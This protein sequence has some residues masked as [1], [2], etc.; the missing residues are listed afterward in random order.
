MKKKPLLNIKMC[1]NFLYRSPE[2]FPT[3]R[4]TQRH[5]HSHTHTHT[6]SHTH[7]HTH[8]H[9]HTHT[10]THTEYI[11][12][13]LLHCDVG[14]TNALYLFVM[15]TLPVLLECVAADEH[16]ALLCHYAATNGNILPTF[17]DKLPIPSSTVKN[18]V[19]D[20]WLR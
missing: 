7:T 3:L 4:R 20:L 12:V 19:A 8:T 5:T 18:V 14:F 2:A 9:S 17:R 11:I 15:R 1:F 16:C 13:L 6:H 10:H